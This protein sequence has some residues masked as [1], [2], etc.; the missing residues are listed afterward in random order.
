MCFSQSLSKG[1]EA[2]KYGHSVSACVGGVDVSV[3][4]CVGVSL[5]TLFHSAR[6][7]LF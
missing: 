3:L 1:L 5:M 7:H 6:D 2:D 4:V